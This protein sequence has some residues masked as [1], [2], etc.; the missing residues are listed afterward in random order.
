MVLIFYCQ[1]KNENRLT[2]ANLRFQRFTVRFIM[3]DKVF[4][5]KNI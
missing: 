2:I 3:V 5:E 4:I 1:S